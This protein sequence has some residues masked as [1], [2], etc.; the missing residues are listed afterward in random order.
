LSTPTIEWTDKITAWQRSGLNVAAWCR[1]NSV[2]YHSFLFWRKRLQTETHRE[3]G[4]FVEL[5][6]TLT[7]SPILLECNGVTVHVSSGFDPALLWDVL[8]LIKKG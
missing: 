2:S 3:G 4:R 8:S 6:V 1:N 7:S 5:A